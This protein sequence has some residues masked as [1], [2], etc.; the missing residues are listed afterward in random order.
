[1]TDQSSSPSKYFICDG[2]M[3][4]R[5]VKKN[6][7]LLR[8]LSC[9]LVQVPAGL[10]TTDRGLSIYEDENNVFLTDRNENYY[11]D[12]TYMLGFQEKLK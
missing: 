3:K 5:I 4:E 10:A 7:L 11:F 9:R 2:P 1:M 6:R 12:K 8:C